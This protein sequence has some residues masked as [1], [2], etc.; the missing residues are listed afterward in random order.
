MLN[1]QPKVRIMGQE[2]YAVARTDRSLLVADLRR[3]LVSEVAWKETGQNLKVFHFIRVSN[4][5]NAN[6]RI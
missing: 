2:N 6:F 5:L 4:N 3:G 1:V